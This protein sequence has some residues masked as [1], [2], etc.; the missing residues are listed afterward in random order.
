MILL[1]TQTP[2]SAAASV[3]GCK[4]EGRSVIGSYSVVISVTWL[5]KCC[6]PFENLPFCEC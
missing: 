6:F 4:N 5:P 2:G 3:K 1:F